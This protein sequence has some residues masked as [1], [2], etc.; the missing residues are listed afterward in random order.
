MAASSI[1]IPAPPT[2][3]YT[4]HQEVS[5]DDGPEGD[6]DRCQLQHDLLSGH[7]GGYHVEV[8]VASGSL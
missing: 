2:H 1:V 7:W 8:D 3:A 6:R 5:K 4:Q